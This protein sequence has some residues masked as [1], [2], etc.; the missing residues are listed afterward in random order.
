MKL[1]KKKLLALMSLLM[2]FCICQNVSAAE[3]IQIGLDRYVAEDGVLKLYVNHNQGDDFSI[4]GDNVKV[5]FGNN[6][7]QTLNISRLSDV[8]VPISYKCV[9]DVSGSMSQE[10]IDQAKA[11][12]KDLANKKKPEDSIAITALGNDLIQSEYMT[13]TNAIIEKADVLTLTNEDTNL[14]YAIVQE[15]KGLQT[16]DQVNRK[17]CLI[18]F[19]DGADDQATGITREEAE[20]AVKDSHIPVFTVGL[21]KDKDSD[22]SKEMAKVLGSFARISSGG[23]HFAPALGEGSIETTADTIMG[24]LNRSFVIEESLENV[25][26]SG[27]EVVLKITMSTATGE[28]AEDSINVPESDIKIIR[29][30]QQ[31][32]E[33]PV[34][35]EP[36]VEEPVVEEPIEEE[37]VVDEEK[38]I[39]GLPQT[40]FFII[41]CIL[42]LAIVLLIVIILI[43]KKNHSEEDNDIEQDEVR[44][45]GANNAF[46]NESVTAAV[47]ENRTIGDF[48]NSGFASEGFTIAPENIGVK[49]AQSVQPSGKKYSVTLIQLGKGKEKK[50]DIDLY[51]TYTIG[52]SASRCNLAMPKDTALSGLHCTLL[53]QNGKIFLRDEKSTN[54]TFVNGVPI[55][56]KFE[57]NQDDTILLGSYEYR[58][59][60]K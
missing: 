44:G 28:T 47:E 19:S 46:E 41:T 39:L 31:K 33:E 1:L 27:K 13:D 50:Y 9:V 29:E 14:Y 51:D 10:R 2:A 54:G 15:I 12:I 55:T 45:Q 22:K 11:I 37:P 25:D 23:E 57:L 4:T 49:A 3:P 17:R 5:V 18:I 6:E 35:E 53:V 60:W 36:V 43:K 48:G 56:G 16:T 40:T 42:V 7:M 34:V 24:K 58:I 38:T 59:T 20:T 26:V 32:I 8:N 30:E 21:L 52:R